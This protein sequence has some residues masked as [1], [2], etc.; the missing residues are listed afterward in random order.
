MQFLNWADHCDSTGPQSNKRHASLTL[1]VWESGP[2]SLC[3]KNWIIWK[4]NTVSLTWSPCGVQCCGYLTCRSPTSL[5]NKCS[6]LHPF[7]SLLSCTKF[8]WQ[9]QMEMFSTR[10]SR[11]SGRQDKFD[12]RNWSS[13]S[14]DP[15]VY[16]HGTSYVCYS[17]RSNTRFAENTPFSLIIAVFSAKKGSAVHIRR[18]KLLISNLRPTDGLCACNPGGDV[19]S[20]LLNWNENGV[21]WLWV[22]MPKSAV[23]VWVWVCLSESDQCSNTCPR[24]GAVWRGCGSR[25][26][27]YAIQLSPLACKILESHGENIRKSMLFADL[28][29]ISDLEGTSSVAPT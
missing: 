24:P 21:A 14:S 10:K 16:R 19:W 13:E 27:S 12:Q 1:F 9:A 4:K 20:E 18:D 25:V 3:Q 8:L 23:W 7:W 26:I 5:S 15:L 17:S 2:C 6:A 29:S 28:V 22:I 11:R